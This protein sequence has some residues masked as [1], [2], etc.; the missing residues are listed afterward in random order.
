MLLC[1]PWKNQARLPQEPGLSLALFG[2]PSGSYW[3]A[4]AFPRFV[5][6]G[7]MQRAGTLPRCMAIPAQRCRWHAGQP[8][9]Q[10]EIDYRINR[11]INGVGIWRSS[12]QFFGKQLRILQPGL[13]SGSLILPFLADYCPFFLASQ[14]EW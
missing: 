14:L 1:D 13:P 7:G 5:G 12:L 2:T 10:L 11:L 4:L 3:L 8:C 6:A 9:W